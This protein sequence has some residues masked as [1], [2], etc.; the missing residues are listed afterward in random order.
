MFGGN[1]MKFYNVTDSEFKQFGRVIDIDANEIISVA[2]KIEM[3]KEGNKYI[4]SFE[5]FE[6]L[7]IMT[8]IQNKYFGG[9][10][11]QL[12]YCY[13]HNSMLDALEWHT[14][15]EINIAVTDLIVLLGDIRDLEDGNKYNSEKVKA[16][17]VKKG[18]AIEVYATTLHYCPI[19]VNKDGFGCVVGLIKE[20]NTDLKFKPDDKLLFATN[21]WLIAHDDNKDLIADGAIGGIYGENY[22][23][24]KE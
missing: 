15:S 10:P 24:S 23:L 17:K 6:R 20:T 16:F 21:K 19:E 2:D 3:P 18:E 9:M 4:A 12:G 8:E 14:C 1:V 22:N 13:G 5:K 11:T 7:G